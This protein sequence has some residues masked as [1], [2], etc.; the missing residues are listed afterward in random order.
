M[1]SIKNLKKKQKANKGITL[2]A[3]VVTII[4]LLILAAVSIATLTG[5]NGILTN[6]KEAKDLTIKEEEKEQIGLAYNS[7]IA[8]KMEKG[9]KTSVT[10]S[11]LEKELKKLNKNIAIKL[12]SQPIEVTFTKT[13]NIY[14]VNG[15]NGKIEGDNM[16]EGQDSLTLPVTNETKPYLLDDK[17]E[18]LNNK[19]EEGI[20]VRDSKEN[21]WVWIEVPRATIVYPTAGL[22]IT[23]FTDEEYTK[24]ENDLKNYTKDYRNGAE[25]RDEYNSEAQH[26]FKGAEEYNDHKK[27][28]LKSVYQN[29]GFYIG[30]YEAGATTYVS[31]DDKGIR[32]MMIKQ[33]AYPYNYVTCKKAQELSEKLATE[34]KTSSLMFGVQWDLVL[35]YIE[36]RGI[37]LGT[38]KEERKS[39]MIKTTYDLVSTDWGNYINAD[40]TL[41][42]GSYSTDLG[43]TY[44]KVTG[45]YVKP[46][47]SRVLVTTG[48]KDRNRV[49]NIYDLAGNV[50]E[51]T[52]EYTEDTTGS[53]V[54]RGGY[55]GSLGF[56]SRSF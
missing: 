51:W 54:H 55:C 14:L 12:N 48:G 26:G 34:G 27:S 28:M 33:D 46:E 42:R 11:E 4:V 15:D 18:V 30:R 21:E 40:F 16:E 6:A 2:I 37:E 31:S 9:E 41:T 50:W 53:C 32:E 56:V 8:N 25:H 19:I 13:T 39:K 43:K 45:E 52:L 44:T 47:S 10:A 1:K 36:E 38:T 24:I 17:S 5:E 35:K 3:L 20:V 7:V 29:G 22:E 49:L 23:S